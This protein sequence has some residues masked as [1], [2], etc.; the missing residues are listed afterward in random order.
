MLNKFTARGCSAWF[1]S[2]TYD[3][4]TKC[5]QVPATRRQGEAT[6]EKN[7]RI[8]KTI[9]EYKDIVPKGGTRFVQEAVQPTQSENLPTV[10]TFE[11]KPVTLN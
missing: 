5:P 10:V 4:V 3:E 8:E 2:A 1:Y 7:G 9:R 11:A 6:E